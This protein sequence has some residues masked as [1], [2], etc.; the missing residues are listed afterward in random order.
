MADTPFGIS[1]DE[2]QTRQVIN[3]YNVNRGNYSP[4]DIYAIKQHSFYHNVPFDEGEGDFSIGEAIMQFGQGFASGFTTFEVGEHPDN[5]YEGIA[6][7]L[8]HLVGF[9]PGIAATPV[10]ALGFGTKASIALANRLASVKSV[11]LYLS[12]K[13]TKKASNIISPAL[14]MGVDGKAGA[15]KVAADFVNKGAIKHVTEGAFNLGVASGI[16]AWQGGIDAMIKSTFHG[17]IFGGVFRTLGNVVRTGDKGADKLIRGLSGSLFQGLPSTLRGA[18]TP[19]QVYEYLLGAYF[20]AGE[21]PWTK[22]EAG[23]FMKSYFKEMPKNAK[24]K[25]TADPA[26]LGEKWENLDPLVKEQVNAKIK[27]LGL[28]PEGAKYRGHLLLQILKEKHGIDL[29]DKITGEPTE[30][31]WKVIN[32]IN[33][34][35]FAKVEEKLGEPEITLEG[36]KV[37]PAEKRIVEKVKQLNIDIQQAQKE[38][39]IH[40]KD[41]D[42]LDKETTQYLYSSKEIPKLEKIISEK[43]DEKYRL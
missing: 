33:Q 22:H 43:Q 20:G 28:N 30:E 31:G 6:R 25:A 36:T 29:T 27:E 40:K 37:E 1:L 10:R 34:G 21:R 15:V 9:A 39:D 35:E 42:T 18:T 2:N 13:L 8:G 17:A 41:I 23:K 5:T 11:P 38:L 19:E 3:D 12:S 7:S 4:Q 24:L 26:E 16:A 14:K 32:K